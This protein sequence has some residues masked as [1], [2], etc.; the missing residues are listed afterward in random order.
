MVQASELSMV[1]GTTHDAYD[2]LTL[3][4]VAASALATTL[5]VIVA[6]FGPRW[7]ERRTRPL[8]R[9][10]ADSDWD[11]DCRG[12]APV[13]DGYHI[14]LSNERGRATAR[15]IEVRIDVFGF[16]SSAQDLTG[17]DGDDLPLP[18]V[19]DG[20]LNFLGSDGSLGRGTG[21]VPPG[22]SRR[23]YL[24]RVGYAPA[25]FATWVATRSAA[26]PEG[27][28]SRFCGAWATY[29]ARTDALGW[30]AS[31]DEYE[32][33]LTLMGDNLDAASYAGRLRVEHYV[34]PGEPPSTKPEFDGVNVKW[35]RP[36]SPTPFLK[37]LAA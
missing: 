4:V 27:D 32:V 23:V 30:I 37:T 8:L 33:I 22:A 34:I 29:P 21:S 10:R 7:Q 31:G 24:L 3:S 15:G 36:L 28:L 19:E 26:R 14:V 11:G 1:L 35:L 2:W 18:L 20:R 6:L 12:V 17:P 25:I 5:A 9:L 16:M 13:H